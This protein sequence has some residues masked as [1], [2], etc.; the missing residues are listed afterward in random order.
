LLIDNRRMQTATFRQIASYVATAALVV[1]IAPLQ[2][3]TRLTAD[4]Y[5][6]AEQFLGY[7]TNRLV[8]HLAAQPT[9]VGDDRFW[10]RA[11]T[12]NGTEF[13]QVEAATGARTPAFDQTKI[14]AAL[15]SAA[16][17]NYSAYR[18][19]FNQ[20]EFSSDRKQHL[21]DA[22][23]RERSDIG[24]AAIAKQVLAKFLRRSSAL[25]RRDSACHRSFSENPV[26]TSSA[27]ASWPN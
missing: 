2:G 11:T 20:F 21:E 23:R 22:E 12:E 19:P 14:A 17:S 3:Q 8:L 24:Y 4:D 5:S 16:R 10:Y 6:R 1:F 9:W 25:A 13:F 7:N 15:S 18:L 27:T 26:S